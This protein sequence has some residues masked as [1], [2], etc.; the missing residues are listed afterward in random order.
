MFYNSKNHTEITLLCHIKTVI[1]TVLFL[2]HSFAISQV[3]VFTSS[4]FRETQGTVTSLIAADNN[5]YYCLRIN[6]KDNIDCSNQENPCY[7]DR[8]DENLKHIASIPVIF[9]GDSDPKK[10]TPKKFFAI[11]N[12]FYLFLE[13]SIYTTGVANAYLGIFDEK[14]TVLLLFK[15]RS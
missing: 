10:V 5:F 11:N 3:S 9:P 1:I 6:D 8:F 7:F 13:E 15:I 14:R 12:R 2:W 4:E